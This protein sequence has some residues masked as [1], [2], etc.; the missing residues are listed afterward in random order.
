VLAGVVVED[1]SFEDEFLG[2]E[3]ESLDEEAVESF[4]V[5]SFDEVE[6]D[7]SDEEAVDESDEPDD[8][9]FPVSDLLPSTSDFFG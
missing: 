7:E 9:V 2:E 6:E 3:V 8:S 4:D 1:D 5:E